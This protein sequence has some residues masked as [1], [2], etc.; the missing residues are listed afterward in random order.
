MFSETILNLDY[1]TFDF[2]NNFTGQSRTLDFVFVAFAEYV[3]FLMLAALAIFFYFK[4]NRERAVAVVHAL[5]AVFIGR[6]IIVTIMRILFFR[7]R[8]FVDLAVDSAAN[9]LIAK[10][11]LESAMPSGHMSVMFAMAFAL[12]FHNKKWGTIFMVSALLSGIARVIVGAHFPLDI[13]AGIFVGAFSAITARW[14]VD[15]WLNKKKNQK[16]A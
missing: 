1:R 9:L 10:S 8:P 2:L 16:I 13:L 15:Y 14:M 5:I 12:F 4:K 3:L 11:P 7:A 6:V